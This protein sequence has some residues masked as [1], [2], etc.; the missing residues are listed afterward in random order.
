[1]HMVPIVVLIV[2]IGEFLCKLDRH[3]EANN[4][5]LT[6]AFQHTPETV[7]RIGLKHFKILHFL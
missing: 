7:S 3:E 5:R 4:S 1:M 2:Y 6:D